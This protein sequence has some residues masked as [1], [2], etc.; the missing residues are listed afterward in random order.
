MYDLCEQQM[1]PGAVLASLSDRELPQYARTLA[2]AK[3]AEKGFYDNITYSTKDDEQL[4]RIAGPLVNYMVV[5]FKRIIAARW[6]TLPD[7]YSWDSIHLIL[8]QLDQN[9]GAE[10]AHMMKV[11]LSNG[12][13]RDLSIN[14]VCELLDTLEFGG[15]Q[16]TLKRMTKLALAWWVLCPS[17]KSNMK[18]MIQKLPYKYVRRLHSLLGMID[19]V[20][21]AKELLNLCVE[22]GESQSTRQSQTERPTKSTLRFNLS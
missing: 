4:Y 5:M 7:S 15:K 10:F 2:R 14:V 1:T 11:I 12:R 13:R 3:Q 8:S 17:N 6:E 20:D 22:V 21:D 18:E 9:A 19:R 16:P